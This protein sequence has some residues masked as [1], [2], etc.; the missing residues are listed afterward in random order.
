MRAGKLRHQVTIQSLTAGSP[1]RKPDGT[2]DAAWTD[3]I[4]NPVAAS[5]DPVTGKESFLAGGHL[6]E[7]DHKIRIRYRAGITAKQRV[8]FG[9]RVFD[10]LAVLNWEERNKELLLLCK[11]G[12]TQG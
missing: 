6:A 12:L 7:V 4:G 2:L 10:I 8:L 11:E 5:I 3:A 9:S 1:T